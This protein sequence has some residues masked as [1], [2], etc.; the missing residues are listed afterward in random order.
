MAKYIELDAVLAEI[1]KRIRA[2]GNCY[3]LDELTSLHRTFES[4][5]VKEVDFHKEFVSYYKHTNDSTISLP[6]AKHFF[7]LGLKTQKGDCYE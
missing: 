7:E 5:E 6:L 3:I 1:E 4:L 2:C